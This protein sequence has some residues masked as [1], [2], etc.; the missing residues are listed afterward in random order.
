MRSDRKKCRYC[1]EDIA[2]EAIKCR[3]CGEWLQDKPMG[4]SASVPDAIR[5]GRSSRILKKE[6]WSLRD[7]ERLVAQTQPYL[8]RMWIA[9]AVLGL[10]TFGLFWILLLIFWLSYRL[11]RIEY[12][13]TDRRVLKVEGWLNRGAAN[14]NLEKIN[15]LHYQRALLERA[16]GTGTLSVDTAATIGRIRFSLLRDEDPF[17]QLLDAEIAR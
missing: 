8:R 16:T 9:Y 17:R 4:L 1:G 3:Y 11:R 7:G 12:I 13:V 5:P 14:A 15:E 6:P 10:P 2:S